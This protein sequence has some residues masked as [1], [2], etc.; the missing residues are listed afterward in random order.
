MWTPLVAKNNLIT[1][2]GR[3][4]RSL[5]G[6]QRIHLEWFPDEMSD[7]WVSLATSGYVKIL[8]RKGTEEIVGATIVAEHA[9]EMSLG[10][11]HSCG[12]LRW[13]WIVS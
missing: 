4:N 12:G 9:G 1:T 3:A 2:K 11:V 13:R 8:C 10:Q 6:V 5:F 7:W